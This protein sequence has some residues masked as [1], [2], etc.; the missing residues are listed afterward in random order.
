[1]SLLKSLRSLTNLNVTLLVN[2]VGATA[3]SLLSPVT[4][5][6]IVNIVGCRLLLYRNPGLLQRSSRTN[7]PKVLGNL[8]L[9]KPFPRLLS[10]VCLELLQT[11][12]RSLWICRKC[13]MPFPILPTA[14]YLEK[15]EWLPNGPRACARAGGRTL[16]TTPAGVLGS[17][18]R[19]LVD[20]GRGVLNSITTSIMT[21]K[22]TNWRNNSQPL[23]NTK[24]PRQAALL[25][26]RY[27]HPPSHS[28]QRWRMVLVA[29]MAAERADHTAAVKAQPVP[30]QEEE[31]T[32]V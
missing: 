22:K 6:I 14:A 13:A 16:T 27:P 28:S 3:P 20:D 24:T 8:K 1:M 23:S 18:S 10:A 4:R 31:R 29:R 19:T 2:R 26:L 15:Q 17:Q 12:L 25:L 11:M 5:I 7:G 30:K 32:S 21:A 9:Y